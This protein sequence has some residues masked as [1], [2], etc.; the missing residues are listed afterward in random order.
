MINV[1]GGEEAADSV[2]GSW[3]L[4]RTKPRQEG[5]AEDNLNRQ[6]YTCFCPRIQVQRIS[7]GRRVVR[8]DFM[9]PGYM[10]IFM[11]ARSDWSPICSTY[12]IL[13]VVAFG[14]QP[15]PVPESIIKDLQW[16]ESG[17]T[18]IREA[19]VRGDKLS[20]VQGPFANLQ[21]EFESFDGEG[22]VVVM[23]NFL[24]KQRLKMPLADIKSA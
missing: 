10:F 15:L 18:P 17:M 4:L 23:L 24:Q 6:S 13:N 19:F 3:Y 7:Q 16:R 9:F 11:G 22:R 5:R 12:G 8:E 1:V 2:E 14:G 21:A 20:I